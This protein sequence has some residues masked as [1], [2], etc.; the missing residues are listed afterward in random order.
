METFNLNKM[1]KL[2]T[3][4]ALVLL[5]SAATFA[6]TYYTIVAYHKLQPGKTMDDAIAVEKQWLPLHEARKSAGIISG[7][8][9]YVPYNNMKSVGVDCDY[10]TVNSGTD[11][12]KLTTYP[13]ELFAGLAK[14]DPGLK[15]LVATT[16]KTQTILRHSIGKRLTG[17]SNT[18]DRSHFFLFD[19]M[20]V[21]DGAAYEAFE[22]KV[23]KVQEERVAAGNISAWSLYQTIYPTSDD[24]LFN[25]STAQSFDKLSKLDQAMDS[26]YKAIPKA[27]GISAEEFMKQATVKRTMT[28]TMLTTVALSTK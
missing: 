15:N 8:A 7:W 16:A 10:I 20:K 6:Q 9:M 12:D 25:Y 28:A 26:Y 4:L 2:I 13:L 24:V 14:N 17:T 19:L 1:K 21:S 22:T 18:W 5:V 23:Q 11:L 3:T 27:L